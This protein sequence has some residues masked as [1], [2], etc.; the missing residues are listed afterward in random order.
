[1]AIKL[2]V[3]YLFIIYGLIATHLYLHNK[4]TATVERLIVSA[5]FGFVLTVAV[6]LILLFMCAG[7]VILIQ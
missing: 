6:N 4:N 7:I 1:M 3:A 2:I 5:V